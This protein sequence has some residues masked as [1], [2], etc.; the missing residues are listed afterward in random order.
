MTTTEGAN[1][2]HSNPPRLDAFHALGRIEAEGAFSKFVLAS[3]GDARDAR[4]VTELVSGVTRMQKL[5]DFWIDRLYKGDPEAMQPSVRRCLR[6]GLYEMTHMNTPAHAVLN[7]YVELAR[8]AINERVVGLVNGTLRTASRWDT[9]PQ[10]AM[11]D[12][13]ERLAVAYSHP[14]WLVRKWLTRWGQLKTTALLEHNN[15]RPVFGI[16]ANPL[17]PEASSFA[18]RLAEAEVEAEASPFVPQMWRAPSVQAL[19]RDGLLNDGWCSIQDEAAALAVHLLD[20]KPGQ[21]LFDVCAAPGGKTCYAAELTRDQA[22]I[23]ASDVSRNRTR[24]V[25][26]SAKRLGLTSIETVEASVADRARTRKQADAVLVDAPCSG[27]GVL[28]KRADMRW[29][30]TTA[31]LD[32]LR[33]L[34]AQLLRD[35]AKLVAPGGR[36]VYA[37]CS[38]EAEENERQVTRFLKK[39]PEF[40]LRSPAGLIPDAFVTRD[41]YYVSLPHEHGIDGAF[42]AILVRSGA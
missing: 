36:L 14:T 20:L 16:R 42:G 34:Q 26:R 22:T 30:R 37:T 38:I 21:T 18:E 39:N 40:E 32:E 33:A 35:A 8:F 25:A 11:D 31:E 3:E 19:V 4:F 2:Q 17:H 13:A 12:T 10:P 1:A 6:M 9:L 23:V 24:L 7:E 29:H 15:A 27:T 28:G 5:L 41:G